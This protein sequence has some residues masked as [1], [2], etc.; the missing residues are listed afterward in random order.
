M[1]ILA[2]DTSTKFLSIACLENEDVKSEFHRDVGIKHSELLIP[3]IK[4]ML[5]GLSWQAE[6][7]GLIC[8]GIGPGSFTGLRIAAVTVKAMAEALG[9]AVIGVPDMDAI[10]MNLPP[11]VF[12]AAKKKLAAPFLD[13]RKGKVYTC[14]YDLSGPGREKVTEYLLVTA[15]DFLSG[16]KENEVLFFGDAVEKYKKELD[17]CRLARVL[18]IDW[19]PRAADVG[20]IGFKR[21]ARGTDDP[22]DIE[23]LYLHARD[24]GITRST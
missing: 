5:H 10:I 9:C 4:S 19:Y 11:E 15:S 13:A 18:E 21:S 23:P 16:L 1:K 2:I 24:C 6:E 22:E 12:A 20:R 3:E 17:E 14:I 7:L 8:V